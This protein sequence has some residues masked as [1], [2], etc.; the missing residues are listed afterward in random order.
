MHRR[1]NRAEEEREQVMKETRAENRAHRLFGR[2]LSVLGILVA[3]SGT[4]TPSE[5]GPLGLAGI[6]L[7]ALGFALGARWLGAT[8][9]ALS[10]AEILLGTL[11]S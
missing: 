7:G 5:V 1:M 2:V 10:W 9:V 6:F 3:I 4:L 8:A 11:T